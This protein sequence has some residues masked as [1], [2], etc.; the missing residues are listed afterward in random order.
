MHK[1]V[2]SL[3]GFVHWELLLTVQSHVREV[4]ILFW[5]FLLKMEVHDVILYVNDTRLSLPKF[6]TIY[7]CLEGN[8]E[9]GST[10]R[11]KNTLL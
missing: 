2:K 5:L 6:V 3:S 9:T 11:R 7:V 8:A 1:T 4:T 10:L